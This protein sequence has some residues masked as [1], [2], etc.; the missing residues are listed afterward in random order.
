MIT[1]YTKNDCPYC[2]QAKKQ[3][4]SMGFKYEE[5]NI[6]DDTEL[7]IGARNFL[8]EQGHKNAPQ[9]YYR[10]LLL[11]DGGASG[12]AKMTAEDVTFKMGVIDAEVDDVLDVPEDLKF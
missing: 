9:M 1:I 3:L 6:D 4:E 5:I 2:V 11:V 7:S 8:I 12:L 10:N